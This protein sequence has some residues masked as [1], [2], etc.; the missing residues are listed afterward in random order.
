MLTLQDQK[1]LYAIGTKFMTR[2]KSPRLCTVID[3]HRTYNSAGELVRI[4]YVAT[5]E[6]MGQTMVDGDVVA[7]TIAMGIDAAKH[8]S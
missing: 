7:T 5:H 2:G 6:F 8:A 4:R 3:I 1:G